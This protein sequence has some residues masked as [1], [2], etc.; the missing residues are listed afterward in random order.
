MT[1]FKDQINKYKDMEEDLNEKEALTVKF[2]FWFALYW[3]ISLFLDFIHLLF[4]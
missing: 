2:I 1:I 4:F 3:V